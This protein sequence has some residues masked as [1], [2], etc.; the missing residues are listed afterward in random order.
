MA[1][2]RTISLPRALPHQLPV[3]LDPARFK[4]VVCGRRWGKTALGLLATVRGHGPCRGVRKGAIDGGKIWWVAPDYPTAAEIWRDLKKATRQAWTDKD[5]VQR[6]IELPSGGSVT[7]RS[8]HDPGSLVAVGLDGL[9]ID[10]AGKTPESAWY[11]SLRPT[12][13]DRQGWAV[14]IGTPKGHNWFHDLYEHAGSTDGW[15]RWQRPTWDNP[16]V[17]PA[18]IESARLD[19]PRYF[20]QEYGA[21]FLSIEGA[22]WPAEYFPDSIWFDDWP[23]DLTIRTGGLDP[24]KGKDAKSGDYSA[25]VTLGRCKDGKLWCE[26][27]LGRRTAEVIVDALLERHATHQAEAWAIET[28]QFQELLAVQLAATARARGMPLPIVQMVNTVNKQ[29]RIRRLGPY[30]AR[31]EIRFRNTP[32]TRLLVDQLR[33]FPEGKHDDG[34]DALEMALRVMIDLW[35]GRQQKRGP[36]RVTTR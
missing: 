10:E 20:D 19:S 24:S 35:N 34:P 17:P 8:A 29:V 30:L 25:I 4:V 36:Q 9:V 26:A 16:L 11:E 18:E 31:G 5:E 6:R 2:T 15:A 3:L 1:T 27:D 21:S 28:N 32:G 7:V 22:E 23:T 14:F 12:L 33:E 13:S